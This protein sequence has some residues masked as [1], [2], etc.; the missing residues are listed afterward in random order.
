L[1]PVTR[2]TETDPNAAGISMGKIEE[3]LRSLLEEE[4]S[5]DRERERG[6]ERERDRAYIE[7]NRQ[8]L[9]ELSAARARCERQEEALK[10]KDEASRQLRESQRDYPRTAL[11]GCMFQ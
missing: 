1:A 11:V 2:Q 9:R 8:M 7:P 3:L 6:R 4:R 10:E 5:K